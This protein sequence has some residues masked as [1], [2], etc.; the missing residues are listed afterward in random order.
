M[1]A[2]SIDY[3]DDDSI[4]AAWPMSP[5]EDWPDGKFQA[6]DDVRGAVV[7]WPQGKPEQA[8]YVPCGRTMSEP[9]LEDKEEDQRRAVKVAW[10]HQRSRNNSSQ[11]TN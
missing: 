8:C 3:N 10:A 4:I 1:G 5:E 7:Q 9:S 11:V 6:K 2:R